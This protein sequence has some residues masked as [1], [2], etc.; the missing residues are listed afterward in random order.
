MEDI[1][2]WY[3]H[4]IF[5][6]NSLRTIELRS[7]TAIVNVF[8]FIKW[9]LFLNLAI[10]VLLIAF[11]IGPFIIHDIVHGRRAHVVPVT[12]CTGFER[13]NLDL[14]NLTVLNMFTTCCYKKYEQEVASAGNRGAVQFIVTKLKLGNFDDWPLTFSFYSETVI[15]LGNSVPYRFDIAYLLTGCAIMFLCLIIMVHS[16]AN[17]VRDIIHM[18]EGDFYKYS[19]LLFSGWD[20][21]TNDEKGAEFKRRLIRHE[22]KVALQTEKRKITDLLTT[23][24]QKAKIYVVRGFVNIVVLLLLVAAAFGVFYI[25]DFITNQQLQNFNSNTNDPTAIWYTVIGFAPSI[26]ISVLNLVSPL[27]LARVSAIS[28][29][30]HYQ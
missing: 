25:T 24:K 18:K 14:D 17:G 16:M 8:L 26:I 5:L 9:T 6:N 7:G 12:N 22:M 11:V 29:I 21:Y 23:K 1:T 27:I 4:T 3:R 15:Q 10:S 20:H 2:H 30:Y 19:N 28:K 13:R